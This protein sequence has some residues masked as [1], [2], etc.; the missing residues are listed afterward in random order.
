MSSFRVLLWLEDEPRRI[1]AFMFTPGSST[2]SWRGETSID[3]PRTLYPI[4]LAVRRRY[5]H[6]PL[7]KTV[8]ALD[9]DQNTLIKFS[10]FVLHDDDEGD[11]DGFFGKAAVTVGHDGEARIVVDASG[12]ILKIFARQKWR[13]CRR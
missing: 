10:S 11:G 1:R 8:V 7:T 3:V 2:S 5:W 9:Y 6:D 4:G 12:D 13:R